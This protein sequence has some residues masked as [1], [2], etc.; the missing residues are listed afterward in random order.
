LERERGGLMR[1][2]PVRCGA[3]RLAAGGPAEER[4]A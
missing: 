3:A 2:G 4:M 1:D